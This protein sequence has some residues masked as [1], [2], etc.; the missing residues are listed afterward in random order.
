MTET[1]VLERIEYLR[2]KKGWSQYKLSLEAGLT[3]STLNNMFT[4][5]T[6]PSIST[7]ISICDAWNI[8]LSE[9]FTDEKAESLILNNSEKTLVLSFR[10]LS[11]KNKQAVLNL[12]NNLDWRL[13]NLGY[14][15]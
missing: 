7:L 10:S 8:T 5:K 14:S 3:Q 15:F 11:D 9:F 12:C 4:R 13:N 2:K 6:L 1:D